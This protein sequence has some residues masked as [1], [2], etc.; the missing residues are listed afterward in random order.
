MD[1]FKKLAVGAAALTAGA[2]LAGT[3]GAATCSAGSGNQFVGITVTPST[4]EACGNIN[5]PGT[6]FMGYDQVGAGVVDVTDPFT[7]GEI[8]GSL[9]DFS[10]TLLQDVDALLVFFKQAT[11]GGFFK[12]SG[13]AI[14]GTVVSG[15]WFI[16]GPG[17]P[18]KNQKKNEF[19]HV[20][21]YYAPGTPPPPEVVP[22]PASLP[23]LL[24]GFGCVA[25]VSRRKRKTA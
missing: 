21:L 13:P 2:I 12:I 19:S 16:D 10:I 25:V 23:L 4:L 14:A 11:L 5:N 9:G 15:D 1:F 7:S 24:A 18:S 8:S 3:A 6:T 20:D 22:L 17:N